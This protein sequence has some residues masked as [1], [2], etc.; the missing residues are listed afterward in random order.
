MEVQTDS[1]EQVSGDELCF[2]H[3]QM[4]SAAIHEDV[5]EVSL[6]ISFVSVPREEQQVRLNNND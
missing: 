5:H 2:L 1:P 4:V 3:L 6:T